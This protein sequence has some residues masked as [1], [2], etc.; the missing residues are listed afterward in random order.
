MSQIKSINV[1]LLRHGK[2]LGEPAL[3]GHTDVSVAA[4]HQQDIYQ[5]LMSERLGFDTLITSPLKRCK[6]LAELIY[7]NAKHLDYVV[8]HEWR[9]ISFGDLDG[10]PFAT[11][12]ESW[13]VFETFWQDPANSGLPNAE[14]L[15]LFYQRI[16]TAWDKFMQTVEKDTLIVCHGGTIRMILA[17]VL[18]LDWSN[19]A[20]YSSLNIAHHSLTHIQITKAEQS[21]PRVCMIGKPL[22]G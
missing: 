8:A 11:V 21:Y 5:S 15:D 4:E 13:P 1:Y 3:Y 7:D 6:E 22:N 16:S 19:P 12:P 20:L 9:E 18:E 14:S 10:V 17:K 2:T